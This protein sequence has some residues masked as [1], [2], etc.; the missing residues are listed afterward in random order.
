MDIDAYL[1]RIGYDGPRRAD[2]ATLDALCL[3]H[4]KAIPFENV[5][6]L[7]D[8]GVSLD[9]DDVDEKLV[10]SRRGGYCF[11]HNTL[12]ARALTALGFEVKLLSGRVRISRPA[13]FVPPRTHVFCRVEIGAESFLADVGVGGLSPTAALRLAPDVVQATPHEPRRL[14]RE[15]ARWLHQVK[16]GDVWSD[17]C[18]LTLEEMPRIDREVANWY[19]STHPASHFRGRLMVARALDDG[20]RATLL[21]NRLTIRSRSGEDTREIGSWVEL[22][23]VLAERFGVELPAGAA[24]DTPGLA[25]LAGAP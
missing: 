24:F 19:T 25:G 17:V 15:P 12:L 16:L 18:E 3:A 13:D 10:R 14:L 1:G 7:L 4:V 5:D 9:D 2:R 6:V 11:E 8:R 20:G 21:D 23:D 22:V